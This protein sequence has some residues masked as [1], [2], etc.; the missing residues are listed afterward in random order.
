MKPKNVREISRWRDPFTDPK[1]LEAWKKR[2]T[3]AVNASGIVG[4]WFR[5][6]DSKVAPMD[7]E[8]GDYWLLQF[9]AIGQFEAFSYWDAADQSIP[10]QLR[11]EPAEEL[12]RPKM[13]YRG[14]TEA[15]KDR[16]SWTSG[17]ETAQAFLDLFCPDDGKI[18]VAEAETV[19]GII[20]ATIDNPRPPFPM[21]HFTEW[22]IQPKLDTIRE[23]TPAA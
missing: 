17:V 6:T 14:A 19:Y 1:N 18:W 8:G 10:A 7:R 11:V 13:L 22:I 16:W 12:P 3:H 20:N 21:G 23:W 9:Q 5:S 2:G 4:S 15:L